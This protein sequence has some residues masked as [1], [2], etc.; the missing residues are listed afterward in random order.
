MAA[1]RIRLSILPGDRGGRVLVTILIGAAI[2]V[3]V[4][5]L[6]LPATSPFHIPTYLVSLMGKYL[7]FALLAVSVDLI[8][9]FC[10]IVKE[11][12]TISLA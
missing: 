11:P 7:A 9:G 10:G 3:P 6:A 4:C 5:N 2:L 8:W 12:D 1:P